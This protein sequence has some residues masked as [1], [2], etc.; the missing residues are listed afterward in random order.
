VKIL[1]SW[2]RDFV[3]LTASPEDLGQ[4]LTGRGF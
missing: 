1:V 2:L 4:A 3:D